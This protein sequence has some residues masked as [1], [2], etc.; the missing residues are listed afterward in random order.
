MKDSKRSIYVWDGLIF[1][2]LLLCQILL[3]YP[4]KSSIY[5]SIIKMIIWVILLAIVYKKNGFPKDN[6]YFKKLGIKYAIMYCFIYIILIYGLGLF[7][8]FSRTIYS[9]TINKMFENMFPV[10]IMVTSREIIR[11]IICKKSEG[12]V[13]SLIFLT[14]TFVLYDVLLSFYYYDFNNSEQVFIFVCLEVFSI[15]A[16]QS[17]FTYITY[18]VSLIPTLILNLVLELMWYVVPIMPD[19]GNYITSVLGILLPYYLYYK[20][21]NMVKYSDKQDISNDKNKIFIP[22]ILLMVIAIFILVSGVGKLKMI[23]IASNSMNPTYYKGDA[24]IYSKEEASN[25]VEG[26]IL[27]FKSDNMIITHRVVDIIKTGNK[28][29]FKT[30]GDNNESADAELVN[31]DN[32]Y[33]KVKYVVKY[34]GYPTIKLLELLNK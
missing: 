34:I 2:Y 19:L 28:L 22:P 13:K 17:L 3:I 8:G 27:V 31:E 5:L 14:L 21:N 32:V 16:K 12:N 1:V 4:F 20:M 23:A 24:I 7:T 6:S 9:H 30:K 26:D 29:Q 18:K 15:I 25:I 11:Y 10:L 33:G